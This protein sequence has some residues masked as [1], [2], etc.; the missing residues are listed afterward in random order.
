MPNKKIQDYTLAE[1]YT[2]PEYSQL[3]QDYAAS[4]KT[5]GPQ[6]TDTFVH[7]SKL[8]ASRVKRLNRKSE[9]YPEIAEQMGEIM[10]SLH[11]YFITESWCGDAAQ[12]LPVVQAVIAEIPEAK[13]SVVLRDDNPELMADFLTDGGMSI[14]IIIVTDGTDGQIL[15]HWGPRPAKMQALVIDRKHS[16]NPEPY[17]T[18]SLKL[19]EMYRNDEGRMIQ[20]EFSAKL[21]SLLN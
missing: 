6:A 14:P 4:G 8:N 11:F 17:D 13:T 1:S 9:A 21:L 12:V 3:M 7:F 2:Y 18:F 5:T 15:G 19:Q 10:R 20:E 16:D